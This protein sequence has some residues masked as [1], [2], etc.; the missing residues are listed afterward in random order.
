MLHEQSGLGGG[1]GGSCSSGVFGGGGG[2]GASGLPGG[3]GGGGGG[4]GE[5][6][7]HEYRFPVVLLST[8][9]EHEEGSF[10]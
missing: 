7:S 9:S 8:A 1:G 2:G 4:W 10:T 5:Q 6:A 3:S